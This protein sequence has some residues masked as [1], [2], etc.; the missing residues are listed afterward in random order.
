[1]ILHIQKYTF[2]G[3]LQR[4][5][6]TQRAG[7]YCFDFWSTIRVPPFLRVHEPSP[8]LSCQ[9]KAPKQPQMCGEPAASL[10]TSCI[11]WRS[12]PR[13]C[14][15]ILAANQKSRGQCQYTC[16]AG[17]Q[18]L[19]KTKTNGETGKWKPVDVRKL[20]LMKA[21][22]PPVITPKDNGRTTIYHSLFWY[23]GVLA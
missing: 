2:V 18:T 13:T 9:G 14:R 11:A 10:V 17:I 5:D 6:D 15:D 8:T 19:R 12:P 16:G 7:S 4:F 22:R 21:H 20:N 3:T 1:M 23:P